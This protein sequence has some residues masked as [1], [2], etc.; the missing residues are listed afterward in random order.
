MNHLCDYF[1]QQLICFWLLM[2]TM[3][4]LQV[5]YITIY[6]LYMFPYC[7]NILLVTRTIYVLNNIILYRVFLF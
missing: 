5:Q 4:M 7:L 3:V 2:D 6:D 1:L